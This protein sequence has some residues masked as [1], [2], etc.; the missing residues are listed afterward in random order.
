MHDVERGAA[1]A[2]AASRPGMRERDAVALLGWDGS[3]LSC[4]LMLTAGTAGAR[5]GC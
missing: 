3:P 2:D 4:H 1:R 5:S